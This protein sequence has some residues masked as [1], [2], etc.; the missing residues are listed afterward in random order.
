[1]MFKRNNGRARRRLIIF[2]TLGCLL[3][4]ALRDLISAN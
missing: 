2:A 1:M 3:A 4:I